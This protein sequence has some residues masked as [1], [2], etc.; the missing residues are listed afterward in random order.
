LFALIISL[1]YPRAKREEEK[2]G[3]SSAMSQATSL[4]LVHTK[5]RMKGQG[6]VLDA[7]T[8]TM[9]SLHVRS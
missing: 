4:R 7:M 9:W 5:T 3:A 2:G 8:R 6:D 1:C